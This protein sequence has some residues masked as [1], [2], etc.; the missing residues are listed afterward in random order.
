M[1][2]CLLL[3]PE[4]LISIEEDP[5]QKAFS[6]IEKLV[7]WQAKKQAQIRLENIAQLLINATLYGYN[8]AIDRISDY[9]YKLEGI[10]FNIPS[11]RILNHLILVRG[12][13]RKT[14]RQLMTLQTS[15]SPLLNGQ[16]THLGSRRSLDQRKPIDHQSNSPTR[17]QRSSASLQCDWDMHGQCVLSDASNR[18]NTCKRKHNFYAINIYCRNLWNEL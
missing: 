11:S 14:R 3:M 5:H 10:C 6:T 2:F 9:L 4:L 16:Y 7:R 8:K 12:I 15:L 17:I 18:E 13:L 1:Q